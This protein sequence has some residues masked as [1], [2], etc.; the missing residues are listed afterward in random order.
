LLLRESMQ[1]AP[2]ISLFALR[3]LIVRS[4]FR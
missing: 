1:G 3:N 4:H 2:K